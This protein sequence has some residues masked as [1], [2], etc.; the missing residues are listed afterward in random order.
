MSHD[1]RGE[2]EATLAARQELGPGHE[3]DL[4][5]G[6]LERLDKRLAEP[7]PKTKTVD[8]VVPLG[9]RFALTVVSVL[10]GIPVTALALTQSG[11]AALAIGWAGIVLVNLIFT[12]SLR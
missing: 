7:L 1:P 4:I 5:N 11:L 9:M 6:F 8:P 3:D 10:A 12:R 2:L